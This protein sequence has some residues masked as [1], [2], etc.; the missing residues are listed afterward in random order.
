MVLL[1]LKFL[2]KS[3]EM[4]YPVPEHEDYWVSRAGEFFSTR[5]H[6]NQNP[7]RRL[8]RRRL[9]THT[10][11]YKYAS[12]SVE[13]QKKRKLYI[14]RAV[15]KTFLGKGVSETV[16]HINGVK[17]DNRVVNLE[18]ATYSENNRH[19]NRTGLNPTSIKGTLLPVSVG[20]YDL[21]GNFIDCYSSMKAAGR[22]IGRDHS[23]ISLC[24]R[25]VQSSAYGYI[26]RAL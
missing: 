19:A 9:I 24:V 23:G 18:W 20:R 10:D 14:H 15:A 5:Y 12:V 1:K 21:N 7:L 13:K 4:I 8:K 17:D 25:G 6:F 26:W 2:K 16:N 11:G 3:R 22:A